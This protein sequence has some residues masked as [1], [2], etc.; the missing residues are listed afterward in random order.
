MSTFVWN[1]SVI[2]TMFMLGFSA[3]I[4]MDGLLKE[5]RIG[6][7]TALATCMAALCVAVMIMF[8]FVGGPN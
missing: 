7:R 3:V 8:I 2:T 5:S 6:F 4:A 1:I